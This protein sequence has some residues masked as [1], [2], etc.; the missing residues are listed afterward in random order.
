MPTHNQWFYPQSVAAALELLGQGS[1]HYEAVAGGSSWH[2]KRPAPS[3]GLVDLTRLP[4]NGVEVCA[5]GLKLGALL[6]VEHLRRDATV[7]ARCRI[8]NEVAEAMRPQQLRNAVT[9]GGNAVQVFP[10]S[11]APVALLAVGAR[12]HLLPGQPATIDASDF[13]A[14]HPRKLLDG[15]LLTAISVPVDTPGQ[16]SAFRKLAQSKV[17]LSLVSAA[18]WVRVAEGAVKAAR[19]V[20]GALRGLPQRVEAAEAALV[21][22]ASD[23]PAALRA[24]QEAVQAG[25]TPVA[26]PRVGRDYRRHTAGVMA[27]RV[28]EQA[29]ARAA[30]AGRAQA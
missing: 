10:W 30:A 9:L 14:S 18:V 24:L 13:Y 12:F 7:A 23:D 3:V 28:A 29:L 25:V 20:I 26:D 5:D 15:R 1:Q 17:D 21:G 16:G 11:D 2:F 8:L 22:S 4:L 27:R 6:T 19:V